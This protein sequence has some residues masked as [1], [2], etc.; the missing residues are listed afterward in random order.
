MKHN[1][2]L[3]IF[4][5]DGT[6][7]DAYK[8]VSSSLNHS[9][10]KH[11]FQTLSDR[12]V[13]RKVGWGETRLIR[14]IVGDEH[15]KKVLK[16]YRRHHKVALPKGTKYLPGARKII[17][18]L[19]KKKYKLAIA[20]NRPSRF[21]R[22]I[23]KTLDMRRH[24]EIVRCAD[25]VSRPKPHGDMLK[26]I[27]SELSLAPKNALYVGD[28]HIDLEAGRKAR[29]KTVAVTTGSCTLRELKEQNPHSII[30]HIG[31]IEGILDNFS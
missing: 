3:V 30:N 6:L 1:I 18:N 7:V 5:L 26:E 17:S 8:A 4:D 11:G 22:T 31:E 29:V 10:K 15:L 19:R 16:T 20:S 23:L 21:T 14:S 2:K 13:K 25:Q 9:L 12:I 24:F 27:L 28:M